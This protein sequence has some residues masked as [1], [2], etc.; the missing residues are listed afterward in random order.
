MEKISV[1]ELAV[2]A[3]PELALRFLSEKGSANVISSSRIQKLG[4][5]LAG[6]S[7][8]IH[9]GRIQIVGQ[10]EIDYLSQLSGEGRYSAI[11]EL[12]LEK[13][14]CVLLTKGLS[15]PDE[16]FEVCSEYSIPILSTSK[17]SSLAI[18]LIT[19]FLEEFLAPRSTIHGVFIGI[20]GIGVLIIGDSGLGKSECALDLIARGHHLIADDSVVVKK[21]GEKLEGSPPELTKEFLEIRGLGILNIRDLFGVSA[22]GKSGKIDLCIE[23]IKWSEGAEIERLGIDSRFYE[24]FSVKIEKFI[25]PVSPG[26]NLSSLVETAARLYL[27]KASGIDSAR[28]LIDSHFTKVSGTQ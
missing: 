26:R 21:I 28:K 2:K 1:A 19:R 6:F 13:I 14:S 24:L 11:R 5:A 7:H 16:M 3:P 15:P 10:S 8:Y 18:T 22:I 23:L 27:A 17:V 12:S 4:L 9:E 25:L 20:F